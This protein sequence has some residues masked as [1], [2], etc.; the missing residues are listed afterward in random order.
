MR[1]VAY[2][3]SDPLLEPSPS[4]E[5]WGWEVDRVYQDFASQTQPEDRPQLEQCLADAVVHPPNYL[6]V[7]RLEE[8]GDSLD[9]VAARLAALETQGCIVMAV[10]QDYPPRAG[11][12]GRRAGGEGDRPTWQ[13]SLLHLASEIQD[14]Q[15]SRRIRQGHARNRLKALPPPGKAPYGYRRGKERYTLDRATAPVVKDF[16]DQFLLFGSL[17]QAVRYLEKKYNKRISVSTGQR[18][19]TN[20]VY[21]G[22]LVYQD[23]SRVQNTHVAILSR[24]EAAQVDRI[25]RRNSRLPP[26]TASAPRSLAGLTVCQACQ[27]GMKISRVMAPRREKEYLYLT[28]THCPHQPKC[29]A[30]DYNTVLEQTILAIC[31]DLPEAVARLFQ[32]QPGTDPAVPP[33]M[34]AQALQEQLEHQETILQQLPQLVQS[35]I[36]DEE[37]A[38][39][40]A[41]RIRSEIAQ[42]QR[43]LATLPPV[44]L[45]EIAQSVSIPQFWRDL[46]EPE[47]RFFF[48]EFLR[49]IQIVRQETTWHLALVFIFSR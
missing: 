18:W 29:K 48:R 37:T 41:Y 10:E 12:T 27:S 1:I 35:G 26:R 31:R 5:L 13:R 11:E 47:R 16:F 3:Y 22:D 34:P 15:R 45:Q 38:S 8:L 43:Q 20:P 21:R 6:L 42:L 9:Q 17:R 14:H 25:L 19:L 39:L 23:G 36:L 28:P 32:W 2:L 33:P 24:E 40:R 7:R 30:L 4:P 44:R 46:S 49:E